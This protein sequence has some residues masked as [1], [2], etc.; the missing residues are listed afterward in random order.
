MNALQITVACA[1]GFFCICGGIT[2]LLYG[3]AR[4]IEA[5]RRAN[6]E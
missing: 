2:F 5:K 6:A 3:I 1:M 4:V